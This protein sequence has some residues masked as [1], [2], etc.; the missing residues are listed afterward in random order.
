MSNMFL[1]PESDS[2]SDENNLFQPPNILLKECINRA[3]VFEYGEDS[4]Q[5]LINMTNKVSNFFYEVDVTVDRFKQVLNLM[6]TTMASD[7]DSQKHSAGMKKKLMEEI[8]R[9][10]SVSGSAKE[11]C[12]IYNAM[13]ASLIETSKKLSNT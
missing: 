12:F 10:D 7:S 1:H 9:L 3:C 2:P 13:V 8:T 4:I 6:N 5:S 11:I